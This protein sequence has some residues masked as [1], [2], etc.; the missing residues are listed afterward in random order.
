MTLT[1]TARVLFLA[2]TLALLAAVAVAC[3]RGCGM[4]WEFESELKIR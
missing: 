2:V 4:L 1:R 3:V